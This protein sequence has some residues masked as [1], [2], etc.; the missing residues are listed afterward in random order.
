MD[1]CFS[2]GMLDASLPNVAMLSAA[3]VAGPNSYAFYT[4]DGGFM[5]FLY[6]SI[7]SH[8]PTT[9]A[10]ILDSIVSLYHPDIT[11]DEA[12]RLVGSPHVMFP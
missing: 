8:V 10:R 11:F 12:P 9:S 7:C 3:R 2:D 5:S 1:C 4:G 6:S